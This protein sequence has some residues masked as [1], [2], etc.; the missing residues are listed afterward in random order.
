MKKSTVILIAV[1]VILLV[2]NLIP[3]GKIAENDT[4]YKDLEYLNLYNA[5]GNSIGV[6]AKGGGTILNTNHAFLKALS[7]FCF[8]AASGYILTAVYLI[9]LIAAFCLIIKSAKGYEI[10]AGAAFAFFIFTKERFMYLCTILP[11]GGIFA[12]FTLTAALLFYIYT[13]KNYKSCMPLFCAAS[14]LIFACYDN[15]TALCA[16]IFG[17]LLLCTAFFGEKKRINLVCG[18]A[19]IV[20]SLV[21]SCSYKGVTYNE[22]VE[23]GINNGVLQY[24]DNAECGGYLS[25]AAFY[26]SHPDKFS[27]HLQNVTNN[28]FYASPDTPFSLWSF[29]K[30]KIMPVKL[31]VFLALFAVILI[32][33]I[34]NGKKNKAFFAAPIGGLFIISLISMIATGII[35]G[36]SELNIRLFG[37]NLAFD[38]AFASLVV[39][40]IYIAAARDKGLKEKYGITQ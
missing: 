35:Y 17:I 34:V 13:N 40:V 12:F 6:A 11:Q 16:I 10:Y 3:G 33:L 5:G 25:L 28:A 14:A 38:F 23:S 21:F 37:F 19:V 2:I 22:N 26:A 30:G 31:A 9:I 8:P 24:S 20:L 18:A 32:F 4:Y 36:I 1:T 27:K 39:Y 7:L 29:V 15:V